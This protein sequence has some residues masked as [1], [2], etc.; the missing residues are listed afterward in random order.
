[1]EINK[2]EGAK[3]EADPKGNSNFHTVSA[4]LIK[5]VNITSKIEE[6]G[7]KEYVIVLWSKLIQLSNTWYT[8]KFQRMKNHYQI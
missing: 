8:V 2:Y 4:H 1:M 6:E 7:R 3:V 5:N